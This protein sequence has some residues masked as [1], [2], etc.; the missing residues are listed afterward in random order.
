MSF[1]LWISRANNI[2]LI[3]LNLRELTHS[4][5]YYIIS[6]HI[7]LNDKTY[8]SNGKNKFVYVGKLVLLIHLKIGESINL[9]A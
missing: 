6:Y 4:K 9:G 5:S 1:A 7:W 3:T 2:F 8:Q